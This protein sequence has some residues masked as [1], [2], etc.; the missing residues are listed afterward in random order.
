[1]PNQYELLRDLAE[2]NESLDSVLGSL[3]PEEW[4]RPSSAAGWTITDAVSHLTFFD[5]AAV[6]ALTDPERFTNHKE[7]LIRAA[8]AGT[9][10]D[11]AIGRSLD[12]P[13]ALL[14]RWRRSRNDFLE[15]AG[16]RADDAGRVGWY[17]PSMSLSSFT[18]ARIMEV[19]AHGVDIRDGVG[20]LPS[21][22]NRLRHIIHIGVQARNFSFFVHDQHDSG[23][24]VYVEANAPNGESWAWGDP[25]AAD[26]V[27]GPALDLALVLTQRRHHSRTAVNIVG[28]T[29]ERWIAVAQTFAGAATTTS[30]DR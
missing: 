10:D 5:E 3:A 13:G 28:P 19:W 27:T 22:S 30:E 21:E 23:D 26:S 20:L 14:E 7:E 6:L 2:E 12:D 18:T 24:P 16:S 1:V 25:S 15:L 11:L 9:S 17:G 29:A 4:S 8:S